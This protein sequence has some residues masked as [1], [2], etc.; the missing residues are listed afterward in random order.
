MKILG[1]ASGLQ[2]NIG[3]LGLGHGLFYPYNLGIRKKMLYSL[4]QDLLNLFLIQI[5]PLLPYLLSAL[6]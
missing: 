5:P 3:K 2:R 4:M 6:P 1:D